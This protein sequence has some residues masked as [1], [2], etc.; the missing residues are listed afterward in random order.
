MH[1]HLPRTLGA[2]AMHRRASPTRCCQG[3]CVGPAGCPGPIVAA[4]GHPMP[5][6]RA[7][8]SIPEWPRSSSR[9][10]EVGA[11]SHRRCGCAQTHEGLPPRADGS[12]NRHELLRVDLRQYVADSKLCSRENMDHIDRAGG[13]FVTVMPRSR[14]E[15]AQ[16]REAIQT[17]TPG[18]AGL[19]PELP[20]P[21][22][23]ARR[24]LALQ[25]GHAHHGRRAPAA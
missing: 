18:P 13:R 7:A 11:S 12:G 5:R 22:A 15:D 6:H 4:H 10:L 3:H 14:L 21:P 8:S 20:L 9:P 24:S 16:F 1:M 19:A 25:A 23:H 2:C 17:R